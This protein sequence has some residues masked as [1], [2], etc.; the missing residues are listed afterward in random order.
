MK[1]IIGITI[2]FPII[3]AIVVLIDNKFFRPVFESDVQNVFDKLIPKII[4]LIGTAA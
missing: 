2:I 4:M 1:P 3:I